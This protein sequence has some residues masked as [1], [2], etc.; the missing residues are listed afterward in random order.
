[1]KIYVIAPNYNNERAIHISNHLNKLKLDY[2][3]IEG[4][5]KNNLTDEIIK[6]YI[7][8][9]DIKEVMPWLSL[10]MIAAQHH[11]L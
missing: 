7:I 9:R 8:Q 3:A 6:D 10:G 4:V 5:N 2:I 11:I 1:M